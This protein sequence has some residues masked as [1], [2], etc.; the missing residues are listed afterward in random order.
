MAQAVTDLKVLVKVAGQQGLQKLAR[1]LD[2]VGKNVAKANFNFDRF[3]KVLKAKERQQTKNIN[4]TRAFANSWRELANSLKIGSREF[5]VATRNAARLDRQ[6]RRT[7]QARRGGF[8]AAARGLGAV[9]GSAVFGG[10]EG[11]IGATLGLMGGPGGALVGGAIGAQVGM[12]RKAAGGIAENV[13]QYRGYQIALAGISNSQEDYNESL[14]AMLNISQ[15]FLIPQKVAIKQFTRLKASIVGAGFTTKETA[16]VFE[17]M[18]AAILA[19]GGS[20]HD[21]NSALIAAAQ[22]FSKGKVSAEELRQ[23]IGERLPGAFT[24]FADSMG[25]STKELDKMLERG[26]V[27]LTNFVTFSE[28]IFKR[29]SEI[30]ETLADS[31]ERAGQRLAVALGMAEIKFGGFFQVV[32]A[33]FQNWATNLVNWANDNEEQLKRN[34][35]QFAVWADDVVYIF[36][37]VGKQIMGI[38]QPIFSWIGKALKAMTDELTVT[39]LETQFKQWARDQPGYNWRTDEPLADLRREAMANVGVKTPRGNEYKAEYR[40]LLIERLGIQEEVADSLRGTYADRIN[41]KLEELFALPNLKFGT[42]KGDGTTGGAEGDKGIFGS[43]SAGALAYEKTMKDVFTRIGET[44]TRAFQ[45]MEDALVNFVMTGKLNFRNLAQSII[46]DMARIAI[47]QAITAPFSAMFG[48]LFSFKKT[49]GGASVTKNALGNVYAKNK[50]V[51]FAQGG[52]VDSPHI[53]PFRDGV[54]LMGEAGSEAIM[55]LRRGPNGKLGVEAHGGMSNNIT[56]NVDATGTDVEGNEA[57]GR[58]LGRLIGAA[59]QAELIKQRRP[60]GILG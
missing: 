48:N 13:A 36:K 50:I 43:L 7:G 9:A 45:G 51:P 53:F 5:N 39:V 60:G 31:P 22:V 57:E 21:L 58:E 19:T 46:R 16:K 4:N 49:G 17:G 56:V 34:I 26:E 40:R 10:P 11:A 44:V 1:E 32:G 12:L 55:P 24:I 52:I 3:T 54:G 23:Q 30:A 47:Q 20:T 33:G 18:A 27:D 14:Q 6:L 35:A 29:Y 42:A 37:E 38:M 2:G 59:V 28:S 41:K 8:G 25:I 15:K